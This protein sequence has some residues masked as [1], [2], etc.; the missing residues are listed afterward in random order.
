MNA[1]IVS[2][3]LL[4]AQAQ[5]TQSARQLMDRV[6]KRSAWRD[7]RGQIEMVL[8]QRSGGR[9]VRKLEMWSMKNAAGESRMLMRFSEPPDVRGTSFLQIEHKAAEDDRR[10]FL[11]ALRRVQRISAS[12][13]KGAFMSSD[14]SY[15]DI[16]PPELDDWKLEFGGTQKVGDTECRVVVG[17]P[18]SK[19]V[20]ADTGYSRVEWLVDEKRLVIMGARY[21]DKDGVLFKRLDVRKIDN[22]KGTPFATHMVMTNLLTGHE[23]SMKFSHLETDTGLEEQ[24]FTERNLRRIAR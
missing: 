10:L 14:F 21:Y 6:N 22:V 23:S 3:L 5:G 15:Y 4:L 2:L 16:G 7:L 24:F 13:K 19:K 12:G 20:S 18:A 8:E 9:R 17:L 1:W 11:P